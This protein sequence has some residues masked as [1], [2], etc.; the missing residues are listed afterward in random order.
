MTRGDFLRGVAGLTSAMM[1]LVAAFFIVAAGGLI[2][3]FAVALPALD[4][5]PQV[6]AMQQSGMPATAAWAFSV[7]TSA[8]PLV[9]SFTRSGFRVRGRDGVDFVALAFHGFFWGLRL[10]DA[11]LDAMAIGVVMGQTA[12]PSFAYLAHASAYQAVVVGVVFILSNVTDELKGAVV[13]ALNEYAA[14]VSALVAMSGRNGRRNG[15][16]RV[17]HTAPRQQTMWK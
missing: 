11:A 16:A 15:A 8:L 2:A 14:W 3:G 17:A 13:T 6:R 1:T 5:V 12:T 7:A 9:Y 10:A 4:V